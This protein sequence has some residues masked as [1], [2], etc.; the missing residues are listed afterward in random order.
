MMCHNGWLHL[1]GKGASAPLTN[2]CPHLHYHTICLHTQ[3]FIPSPPHSHKTWFHPPLSHF[4]DEGLGI[5]V[6][7]V[8]WGQVMAQVHLSANSHL[9]WGVMMNIQ[10]VWFTTPPCTFLLMYSMEKMLTLRCHTAVRKQGRRNRRALFL[11][12]VRMLKTNTSVMYCCQ[13]VSFTVIRW[14]SVC[15]SAQ[16]IIPMFSIVFTHTGWIYGAFILGQ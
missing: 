8:T 16:N 12:Y 3:T 11:M 13:T 14:Q 7:V 15:K 4:L 5:H 1:G 2:S 9:Y 10:Y 6:L